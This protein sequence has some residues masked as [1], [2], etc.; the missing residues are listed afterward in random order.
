MKDPFEK[1][2]KNFEKETGCDVQVT[3]GNASQI[4]TQINTTEEGDVFIAGSQVEVK[5]V[6]EFVKSYKDLV[7]HIPVLVVREGNPKEINEPED[8]EKEG[9]KFIMGDPQATPIGKVADKLIEDFQLRDRLEV[10]ANT[11]TAPAIVTA[12]QAGEADV[13][14][15]WKENVKEDKLEIVDSRKM[16]AYIKKVR[17]VMLTTTESGEAQDLFNDYL[18]SQEVKDIWLE[19][20]YE[21]AK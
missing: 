13:G 7:E 11:A 16:D 18:D 8:L 6:E 15:V 20:G 1:I 4:H 2:A 17:A 10:V 9:L 21:L 3:Y 12:L 14:L 5:P 19:H